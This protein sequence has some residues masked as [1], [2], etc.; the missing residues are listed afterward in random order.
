[1]ESLTILAINYICKIRKQ[2]FTGD[3]ISIFLDNEGSNHFDNDSV[4]ETLKEM[5]TKIFEY[6][7]VNI[8][9]RSKSP[10]PTPS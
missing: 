9:A 7:P 10:E 2:K 3:S 8:A 1:M 6:R 5:Q 4:L